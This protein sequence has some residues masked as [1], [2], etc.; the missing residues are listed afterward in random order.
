MTHSFN[1]RIAERVGVNAAIILES[2]VFWIKKN[3]DN[4]K[5][6]I[7]C[8][9]WTYASAEGLRSTFSYFSEA[10]IR[11][12]IKKLVDEG[13]LEVR[14][15]SGYDRVNWYAVDPSAICEYYQIDLRKLANRNDKIS[16][17]YIYNNSDTVTDTVTDN[18]EFDENYNPEKDYRDTIVKA[19]RE[20]FRLFEL[21]SEYDNVKMT[22][23]EYDK[24][25]NELGEEA[26]RKGLDILEAYK[27]E[28]GKEYKSDYRAFRKWVMDRVRQD[29]PD[30][31]TKKE[32]SYKTEK[33]FREHLIRDKG[34]VEGSTEFEQVL[35][36]WKSGRI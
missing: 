23:T 35:E 25:C 24:L 12:A 11:Y 31:I 16:E 30:L 15:F 20:E 3:Y 1:V 8:N 28:R 2:I 22:Q 19:L 33:D 26:V 14:H 7:D 18:T 21:Q 13:L 32:R 4:E 5:H 27:T 17:C 6:I 34:Y 10:Q 36:D 9:V 29:Y